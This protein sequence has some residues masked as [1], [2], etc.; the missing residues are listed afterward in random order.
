M[1]S[2]G[3][4]QQVLVH[5]NDQSQTSLLVTAKIVKGVMEV[6]NKQVFI[7]RYAAQNK[8]KTAR[9]LLIE[10]PKRGGWKLV[11]PE[12]AME[13][14]DAL[15]RFEEDLPADQVKVLTVQE[16]LVNR[17]G[18]SILPMDPSAVEFYLRSGAI[19]DEVK[20]ALQ[21]AAKFKSAMTDTARQIQERQQT[22]NEVTQEQNR[23][24]ENMKAV[25]QSSDYYKR[26]EKELDT[27]ETQIQAIKAEVKELK[28]KQDQQ[29]KQLEEYLQNLNVG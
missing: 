7:Q 3:I 19:P 26:L 8:G 17:Q 5:N 13:S 16:E 29:R 25:S 11:Q 24:R 28:T 27:Q 18:I 2:Y 23:I 15:Y 4:D 10:H 22:I 12:H 6:T 1:L 9:T 14:T 20:K 21:E